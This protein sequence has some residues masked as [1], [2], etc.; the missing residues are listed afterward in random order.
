MAKTV[1]LA[2]VAERGK[3]EA[4]ATTC[5][6]RRMLRHITLDVVYL[7]LRALVRHGIL[8]VNVQGRPRPNIYSLNGNP[9]QLIRRLTVGKR[10]P[11]NSG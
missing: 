8:K 7:H 1:I 2:S 4:L 5:Y 11:K 9:P 3:A 10:T 6:V